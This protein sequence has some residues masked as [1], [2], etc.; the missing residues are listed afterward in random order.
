VRVPFLALGR[1]VAAMRPELDATLAAVLDGGRFVGGEPVE[2]FE[3]AFAAYCG[4]AY[5]VGVASGTDAVELALRAAGVG[6]G[7]EVI[8]PANTCV[9][10]IAGIEATGAT[11][12]LVDADPAS[13]ALDPA[14]LPAALSARTRAIVPV[15]L[16]G[17]TAEM[18]PIVSFAREHGLRVVEDAAQAHGAEYRGRRAG[19]LGDAAAFSFYPTKNLGALGDAGAV[20]TDDPELAER[21]RL[22]RQYGEPRPYESVLAGGNSRLDTLQAAVLGLALGRLEAWIERRR[23]LADRY[24]A[25]LAGLDDV[26]LPEEL[27]GRRHVFHLFVVRTPGRDRLRERLAE[28]GVETL[29]H[30]PRPV[31]LQPAYARL[32]RA[33]LETSERLCAE[34]VSLPL[35]PELSDEEAE[36]VAGAVRAAVAVRP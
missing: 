31:H 32:A 27:P 16:Y 20:V 35:Y 2:A 36:L 28:R 24:R 29:V 14:A 33:G 6:A 12:V 21:A 15:H 34:V 23:A 17:Q 3:Q 1:R 30:Y 9:P 18:E 8:A 26:V 22:L 10:T 7:D 25:A 5:A 13:F 4:A 11:P 19:T